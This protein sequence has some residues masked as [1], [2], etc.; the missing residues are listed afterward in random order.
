MSRWRMFV[1]GDQNPRAG[2]E[3]DSAIP[4]LYLFD[5]YNVAEGAVSRG[6]VLCSIRKKRGGSTRLFCFKTES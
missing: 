4:L 6:I 2:N 3:F 5:S 1:W